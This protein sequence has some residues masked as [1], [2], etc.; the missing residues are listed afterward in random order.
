MNRGWLGGVYL[1]YSE[2][3]GTNPTWQDLEVCLRQYSLAQVFEAVGRMSVVLESEKVGFFEK[4][5]HLLLGCF[6]PEL[7]RIIAT[8][9]ET[10][11]LASL[12]N[13]ACPPSI[14][15][16]ETS[17]LSV[18]KAAC[19]TS[20]PG[21]AEQQR[22]LQPLAESLLI[23]NDLTDRAWITPEGVSLNSPEGIRRWAYYLTVNGLFRHRERQMHAMAR[24][25]E[26]YLTDRAH[27]RDTSSSYLDLPALVTRSTGF[28]PEEFWSLAFAFM[29]HFANLAPTELATS[30][31]FIN[32]RKYFGVGYSFT[33]D[34]VD[35]FLSFFGRSLDVVAAEMRQ[36]YT[37]LE[38]HPFSI[39][40]LSASPLVFQGDLVIAPYLPELYNKL[41]LGLHYFLLDS[42]PPES[43]QG[44]LIY[45][46]DVFEDYVAHL[47][48]RAYPERPRGPRFIDGPALRAAVPGSRRATP[49]VCDGLL[50]YDD[51]V[52][53]LETKA[54]IL[55]APARQGHDEAAFF[56]KLDEILIR[57]AA[58][59]H[60]TV[61]H[62]R[63]GRLESLGVTADRVRRF[64]PLIV[65][66]Q[67]L[68]MASLIPNPDGSLLY[69]WMIQELSDRGVLQDDGVQ[70]LQLMSAGEIEEAEARIVEG[71]DLKAMLNKK[72][73]HPLARVGSFHN[74]FRT[75]LEG[76]QKPT[77]HF[78]RARYEALTGQT[79]EFFRKHQR[80]G[81][82]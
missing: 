68:P 37:S 39:T 65:S 55:S 70:P 57:G 49:K 26:L 28:R 44:Y 41:T 72:I 24:M 60:E 81:V 80:S 52:V 20:T 27:L 43:R 56:K 82:R 9:L 25:F 61:R 48:R 36:R 63:E 71:D 40:P 31:A 50:L 73:S 30:Q 42:L 14:A 29:A 53:L 8:R 58:Q 74:F 79:V 64:Y 21:G 77:N 51:A 62:I 16:D 10:D 54:K 34:Q 35:R 69:K 33:D 59:L 66:L 13:P 46:G 6:E 19:L 4:Q 7:G 1:G 32:R 22:S 5:A 11:R 23:V 78:L 38:L 17:L 67:T 18:L 3:V 76:D 15:I 75:L 47:M 45:I 12:Q 2:L